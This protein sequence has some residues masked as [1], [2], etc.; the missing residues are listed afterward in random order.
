MADRAQS[1]NCPVT[2]IRLAVLASLLALWGQGQ[3]ASLEV[4][5]TTPAGAPVEDAAIVV[6]PVSGGVP[7]RLSTLSITQKDREF[8]PYL[9][10]VQTGTAVQFPNK[11]PFKHHVFS[12]SPAKTF[13]IKLYAGQP[14][15]PVIFDKPGEVAIGCNIH[16]WMEAYVLVVDSPYFAKTT[17]QGRAVIAGLPAGRYHLRLWQP[18]QKAEVPQSEIELGTAATRLKRVLD[19]APRVIK[20]KPPADDISY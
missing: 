2:F 3:A 10:I 16:D 19:V 4:T 12:F 5:V 13:Q 6:T 18:S 9:T 7:K 20:P 8:I 11:D 1:Q 15:Q 17:G 14:S